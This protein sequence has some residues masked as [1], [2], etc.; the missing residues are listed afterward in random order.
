MGRLYG[1]KATQVATKTGCV[2]EQTLRVWK[3]RLSEVM[4]TSQQTTANKRKCLQ[5]GCQRRDVQNA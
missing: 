1:V 5:E 4:D 3:E 2:G